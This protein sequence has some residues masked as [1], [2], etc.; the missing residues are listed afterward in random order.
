MKKLIFATHNQ[1]KVT[2]INHLLKG[3]IEIQSLHEA[4]IIDEIP[5]PH[6]TLEANATEKSSYIYQ[7]TKENCFSEDTGLEVEGLNGEPGVRSARYAGD[8]CD[9]QKNIQKL[10][11]KLTNISN[12]SAQ[13]KTVISLFL[14]GKEFQFTGICNGKI[15]HE[16]KGTNGFGYDAVFIPEGSDKHFAEMTLEEKNKLSH[17]KKAISLLIAFLN[18]QHAEN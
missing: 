1:N 16:M 18:N 5:E 14:N 11:T 10:L 9:N 2:E 6:E 8:E 17:R 4:G 15:A 7:L 13:F 3:I 12:R